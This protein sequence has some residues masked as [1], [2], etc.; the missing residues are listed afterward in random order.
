MKPREETPCPALGPGVVDGDWEVEFKGSGS[1]KPR[2]ETPSPASERGAMKGD[3]EVFDSD[4][5]GVLFDGVLFRF[6][7]PRGSLDA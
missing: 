6:P 3:C 5:T 1:M 4:F 7:G 2:R